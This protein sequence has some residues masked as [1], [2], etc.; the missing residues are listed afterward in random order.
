MIEPDNTASLKLAERFGFR[1]FG[2]GE[3][4]RNLNIFLE[5]LR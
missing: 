1:E 5:R 4:K 2:R 3:Y